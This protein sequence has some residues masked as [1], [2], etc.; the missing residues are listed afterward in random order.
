[1]ITYQSHQQEIR[2]L[3]RLLLSLGFLA[4]NDYSQ[5]GHWGRETQNAVIGAYAYIG[6]DH[7][8]EERSI[9]ASALAALAS[10]AH[11]HLVDGASGQTS[12]GAATGTGGSHA[13]TGGSH[14]GTGGSHAG[15]GGS[16]AGTGG[17]H[18]GT[19]GSHAGTGGSHAGTGGSHA[20]TGGS[21]AGEGGGAE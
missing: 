10:G 9:T 5:K 12:G 7:D 2:D 17:S 13:G 15:T 4:W 11:S 14:A 19:G 18:A 21:H 16:H 6:W 3:Q 1:M 20:G 8:P